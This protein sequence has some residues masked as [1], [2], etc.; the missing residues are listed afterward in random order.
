M[1]F[2]QDKNIVK[3]GHEI[4]VISCRTFGAPAY[5]KAEGIETYRIP[6]ITLPV[7]EYPFFNLL[8]LYSWAAKL[9]ERHDI[10]VV[11][12]EDGAY[13]T[14][15]LV[16]MVKKLLRKPVVLS[17]QGFPGISWFYGN[18]LVDLVGKLYTLTLGRAV[19][20]TADMVVL[21]TTAYVDDALRLGVPKNRLKVIPRGVDPKRFFPHQKTRQLTRKRLNAKDD[22]IIILFAGRLVPVKGLDYFIDAA[23]ILVRKNRKLLFIIAGDGILRG[24]FEAET[25][26]LRSNIRFIGHRQDMPDV[27]NAADIFVLSSVSEG[28]PNTVLEA[29]ACAKPVISTKVGGANDIILDGETGF[30]IERCDVADLCNA[31]EQ[32]LSDMPQAAK[33]GLK[34]LPRM[35]EHFTWDSVVS[36]WENVYSEIANSSQQRGKN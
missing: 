32:V 18:A 19:L 28:F 25:R 5:E 36:R 24:K 29:S 27:M 6:A 35:L 14:S 3:N 1:R 8:L 13:L 20:K 7:L 21:S 11:H 2:E 31:L 16:L 17:M 15:L 26:N 12:V 22:E 33:M 34:A 10:D 4:H 30:L 9:V 23:K